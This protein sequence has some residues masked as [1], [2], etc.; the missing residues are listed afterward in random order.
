MSSFF[1][2]VSNLPTFSLLLYVELWKI[3]VSLVYFKV[4]FLTYEKFQTYKIER[5]LQM[6]KPYILPWLINITYEFI[7]PFSNPVVLKF[8]SW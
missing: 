8:L 3:A 5:V 2:S 7:Y 1:P 4:F 6:G